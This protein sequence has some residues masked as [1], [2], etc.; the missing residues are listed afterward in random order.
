MQAVKHAPL[1][2]EVSGGDLP[3]DDAYRWETQ[4]KGE[5]LLILNANHPLHA[6]FAERMGPAYE[7]YV[8]IL[9]ALAFAE[10]R[11]NVVHRQGIA[12]YVLELATE[13][14]QSPD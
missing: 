4:P 3:T 10:K 12:D 5:P 14:V 9:I 6:S 1:K 13:A 2:I 8:A 11:W 7:A